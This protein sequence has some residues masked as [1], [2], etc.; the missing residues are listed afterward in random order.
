MKQVN[1][2]SDRVATL[3]D[4]LVTI[5]GESKVDAVAR[6]LEL[7]LTTL[8]TDTK[9]SRVLAWLE[10]QVWPNLPEGV[11]GRSPSKEEQEDLLGF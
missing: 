9:A 2:K 6:A 3:V 1:L 11:R 7:R 8:S 4:R 10:T 5:T